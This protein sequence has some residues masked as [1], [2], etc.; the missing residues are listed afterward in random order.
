MTDVVTKLTN[1]FHVF[2]G[3]SKSLEENRDVVDSVIDDHVVYHTPK[4]DIAHPQYIERIRE[5]LEDGTK[6]D[7]LEI[8]MHEKG[9]EYRVS[10]KIPGQEALEL[11]SIGVADHGKI[12]RVE[13]ITNA[14]HYNYLL[15]DP[16]A[17]K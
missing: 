13:P 6:V 12:I 11:H 15:G 16:K 5:L 8:K 10:L 17:D 3:T 1:Y 14:E 9:V 2:D 7:I 4:G